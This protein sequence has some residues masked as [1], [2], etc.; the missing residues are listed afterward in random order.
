MTLQEKSWNDGNI[1]GFMK[2]YWKSEKLTFIGSSG[3]NKGWENT[4]ARYKKAY[5]DKA[6]MG[7]LFF[8]VIEFEQLGE[9]KIRMT[10]KWQLTRSDDV[11][12]GYFTLIWEKIEGRWLITYDHS[13]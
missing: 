11:L 3:I 7:K 9:L 4:L 8:E 6:A 5:P 2:G 13:S 12:N 10:G 1:D